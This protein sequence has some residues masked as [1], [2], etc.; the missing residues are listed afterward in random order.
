MTGK[1][2]EFRTILGSLD[3]PYFRGDVYYAR[4]GSREIIEMLN[5][6]DVRTFHLGLHWNHIFG[7]RVEAGEKGYVIPDELLHKKAPV[8]ATAIKNLK[9][10]WTASIKKEEPDEVRFDMMDMFIHVHCIS[11]A[12]ITK[13]YLDKSFKE[14]IENNPP[15]ETD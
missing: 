2:I 3:S 9:R 4:F 1:V 8:T 15:K 5:T 10:R 11:K 6:A 12:Q 14:M 13:H 7:R